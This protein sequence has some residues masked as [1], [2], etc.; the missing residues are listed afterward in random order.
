MVSYFSNTLDCINITASP[1]GRFNMLAFIPLQFFA[2]KDWDEAKVVIKRRYPKS[3][4]FHLQ[5][6]LGLAL[7]EV[8]LPFRCGKCSATTAK[9]SNPLEICICEY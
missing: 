5:E 7:C 8:Q 2:I 9:S 3:L 1:R 6:V 4:S